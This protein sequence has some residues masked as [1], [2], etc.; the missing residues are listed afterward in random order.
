MFRRAI[1]I[2]RM[3][4]VGDYNSEKLNKVS[5][6]PKTQN[7]IDY[8]INYHSDYGIPCRQPAASCLRACVCASHLETPRYCGD[9]GILGY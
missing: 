9:Y 3:W 4:L 8:G 7:A 6:N 5:A 1:I 2:T